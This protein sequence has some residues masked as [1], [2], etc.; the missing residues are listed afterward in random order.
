MCRHVH[1]ECCRRWVVVAPRCVC[2][3]V[4]VCVCVCGKCDALSN[5]PLGILTLSLYYGRCLSPPTLAPFPLVLYSFTFSSPMRP[6]PLSLG[7][8]GRSGYLLVFEG[9]PMMKDWLEAIL[10]T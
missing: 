4:S 3:C 5:I 6:P 7:D 1:V 8:T 2:V 9:R 10:K